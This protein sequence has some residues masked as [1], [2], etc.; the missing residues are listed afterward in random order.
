MVARA[1]DVLAT[2]VGPTAHTSAVALA[3]PGARA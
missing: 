2:N 1:A 3:V